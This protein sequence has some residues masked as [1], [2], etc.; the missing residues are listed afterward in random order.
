MSPDAPDN[1]SP[2]VSTLLGG[3]I[4]AYTNVA[5]TIIVRVASN[6]LELQRRHDANA[7]CAGTHNYGQPE[8]E[9]DRLDRGAAGR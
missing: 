6:S 1:G 9:A 7:T 8:P 2:G 4:G 3:P 5:T